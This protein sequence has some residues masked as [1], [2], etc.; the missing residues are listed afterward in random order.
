[1]SSAVCANLSNSIHPQGSILFFPSLGTE[2]VSC[3]LFLEQVWMTSDEKEEE[4]EDYERKGD[5][6]STESKET[7]KGF[8]VCYSHYK[9]ISYR[10][11]QFPNSVIITMIDS[12]KEYSNRFRR[13]RTQHLFVDFCVLDVFTHLLFHSFALWR[14][15]FNKEAIRLKG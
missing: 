1:M 12:R 6:R 15:N 13:M 2:V 7:L 4:S 9:V 10:Y 14:R 5:K 11:E 8:P 3:F